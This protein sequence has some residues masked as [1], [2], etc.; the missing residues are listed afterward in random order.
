MPASRAKSTPKKRAATT[1]RTSAQAGPKGK[2]ARA[3]APVV[4][5][6]SLKS[7]VAAFAGVK[8]VTLER[9][10][11]AD[12]VVLKTGGK[13]FVMWVRDELVFKVPAARAAEVVSAHGAKLFDPRRDGRLMKEWVVVPTGFRDRS[14]LAHEALAFVA[15]SSK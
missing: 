3:R 10:W 14:K 2:P 8:G 4:V 13:I 12:S 9:G 15:R 1:P 6:D 5:P 11:G 7:L